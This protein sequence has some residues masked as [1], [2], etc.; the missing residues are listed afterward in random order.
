MVISIPITSSYFSLETEEKRQRGE[1]SKV[2]LDLEGVVDEHPYYGGS[3]TNTG[4]H[5]VM[6]DLVTKKR[7]VSF[8]TAKN[9]HYYSA[10]TFCSIV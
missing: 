6:K 8:E 3:R 4:L 9:M 2:Y 7:T 10:I 1:I 5:K